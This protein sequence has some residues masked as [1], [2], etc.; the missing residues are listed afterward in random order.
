MTS[1]KFIRQFLQKLHGASLFFFVL[2][3]KFLI[4]Y[5]GNIKFGCYW[6]YLWNY[7]NQKYVFYGGSL[8]VW[9]NQIFWW[10][11]FEYSMFR[12]KSSLVHQFQSWFRRDFL[13]GHWIRLKIIFSSLLIIVLYRTIWYFWQKKSIYVWSSIWDQQV[14]GVIFFSSSATIMIRYCETKHFGKDIFTRWRFLVLV[15]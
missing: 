1:F 11:L 4:R 9:P 14:D 8:W 13:Y 2:K 6:N 10:L 5:L 12:T 15:I 3:R 7:R